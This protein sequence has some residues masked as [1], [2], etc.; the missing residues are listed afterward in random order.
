MTYADYKLINT[1]NML[2]QPVWPD[3][4]N[5]WSFGDILLVY[6]NF[7]MLYL[8][9]ICQN[10]EPSLALFAAGQIFAVVNGQILNK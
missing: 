4:A 7:W 6:G 1:I 3:L 5:L 10:F 2:P 9:R 8:F